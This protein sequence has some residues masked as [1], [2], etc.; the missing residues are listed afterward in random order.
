MT[1]AAYQEHGITILEFF[2]VER[3]M[4]LQADH[5]IHCAIATDM[6]PKL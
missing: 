2:I 4:A 1:T 6:L 3:N 5:V